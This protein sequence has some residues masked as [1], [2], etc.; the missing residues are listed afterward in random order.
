MLPNHA[1]QFFITTHGLALFRIQLID[2]DNGDLGVS[3]LIVKIDV[4]DLLSNI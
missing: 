1:A 4:D 3:L 2:G